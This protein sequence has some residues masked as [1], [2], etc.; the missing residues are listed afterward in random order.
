MKSEIRVGIIG[1]GTIGKCHSRA[2]QAVPGMKLSGVADI[3]ILQMEDLPNDV[4]RFSDYR[5]LLLANIDAVIICSPTAFHA[6]VTLSALTHGKHV[7]VEKPMAANV[8]QARKMCHVAREQGKVL[9]VGMTH[10]F[11]PEFKR[12]KR[13]V[14]DGAIGDVLMCTDKIIEPIGFN[15]L[16]GWYLNKNVAGGGVVMSDGVHL[17]DR[18][19][20]FAGATVRQV[21]G[22]MGNRY[23]CSSIEDF[24]QLFFW[25]DSGATA[26]L[27]MAFMNV[28]HP[29]VCDLD[30]IGT[31][32]S[33]QVHT[34]K[35]YTLHGP[36]GTKSC[37]IYKD[38]PHEYRVQA[39]LRAEI[40]EFYTAIK[41]GRDPVPSPEE[42]LTV[43]EIIQ[44]FY[45]A[46][47]TGEI[48]PILS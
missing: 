17:V 9:F 48:V 11:Y 43:M 6:E 36:K 14:D 22:V 15:N 5:E 41:E 26:Q 1:Y 38:E 19:C 46:A 16:P 33:I 18:N 27:T 21:S 40:E 20:W 24:A 45:T 10:R 44:A 2:I 28:Q 35:G 7:L 3:D 47:E 4:Q 13:L 39:G 8:D 12:A 34:W 30:V 23:L 29:M 32:G 25:F 37:V 31:K 42:C